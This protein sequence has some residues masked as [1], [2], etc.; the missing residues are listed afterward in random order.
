MAPKN[1]LVT[2]ANGY[3]GSAVARAFARAGWTTYGLIRSP[4]SAADLALDEVLPV[5]GSI[6]DVISHTQ[7]IAQLPP[8]LDIIVSTTEQIMNYVPHYNNIVTL[9]KTTSEYSASNGT[10]PLI[11]FTSGCKDYGPGVPDNHPDLAP[12]T[13]TT[14]LNPPSFAKDRA[15]YSLEI[16]NHF[17][18]VLV[19]PTNVYGKTSSFYSCFFEVASATAKRGGPL[20]IP[21]DKNTICHALH[22]DDCGDAYAAIAEYHTSKSSMQGEI[23]NISSHRY[24]TVHELSEALVKEYSIKDGIRYVDPNELKEG[25][26]LWTPML[27][28]FPQWTGSEKLRKL[29]GW[30][31]RRPLFS[32]ALHRYRVAY[33]A[34]VDAKHESV[35]RTK[36]MLTGIRNPFKK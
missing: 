24:E 26:N 3:I 18:A 6:D 7:I 20:L 17:P 35:G 16:F 2:G 31:D 13:E 19:R 9:L 1:V 23:F 15:K 22:V 34:A 33:E 21:S 10:T 29:T 14:P 27:I 32:E 28:D 5:I 36:A 11:I 12:H 4:S 25:E 30:D 8:T